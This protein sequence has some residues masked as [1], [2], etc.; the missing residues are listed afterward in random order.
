M[1]IFSLSS[2]SQAC[3][4]C[5]VSTALPTLGRSLACTIDRPS[6]IF[7]F[8]PVAT[9]DI[10]QRRRR[11][12]FVVRFRCPPTPLHL[13]LVHLEIFKYLLDNIDPTILRGKGVYIAA[14]T[15]FVFRAYFETFPSISKF[16]DARQFH[17]GSFCCYLPHRIQ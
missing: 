4:T 6:F 13:V 11:S 1:V 3:G 17:Q 12:R 15:P 2:E 16:K 7:P 10:M 9:G 8:P 14:E 5:Q